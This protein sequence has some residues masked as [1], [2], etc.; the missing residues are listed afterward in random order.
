MSKVSLGNGYSQCGGYSDL[1]FQKKCR[2][3][4]RGKKIIYQPF[5][6]CD[7]FRHES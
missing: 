6:T 3:K 5:L 2:R 1:K 4:E 7:L